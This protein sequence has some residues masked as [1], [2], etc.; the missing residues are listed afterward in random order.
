MASAALGAR[1]DIVRNGK[2]NI[3]ST[4]LSYFKHSLSIEVINEI[5]LHPVGLIKGFIV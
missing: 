5:V 1:E 3:S 4:S 2:W